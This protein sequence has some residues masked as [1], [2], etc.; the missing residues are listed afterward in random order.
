MPADTRRTLTTLAVI[1]V[2]EALLLTGWL[3]VGG[4]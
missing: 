4:R 1:V 2:L 3:A